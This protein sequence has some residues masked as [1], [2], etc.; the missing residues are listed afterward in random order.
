MSSYRE[1]Y[2][3]ESLKKVEI[4]ARIE[5][6][7]ARQYL[8]SY[9]EMRDVEISKMFLSVIVETIVHREIMKAVINI[10]KELMKLDEMLGEKKFTGSDED[11]I[12]MREALE[13]HLIIEK[14]M[15]RLYGELADDQNQPEVLREIYNIFQVN[16]RS[17][18]K[19]LEELLK[20][21]GR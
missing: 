17:H 5:E 10:L 19:I 15:E 11:R 1:F 20:Y 8:A 21:I 2:L 16:E 3:D 13:K 14:E 6:E 4:A 12:R 7:A 9:R 18:H